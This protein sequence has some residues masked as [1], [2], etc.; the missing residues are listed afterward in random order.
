[1]GK[2]VNGSQGSAASGDGGELLQEGFLAERVESQVPPDIGTNGTNQLFEE[3]SLLVLLGVSLIL[4]QAILQL[5]CECVVV[6]S[7]HL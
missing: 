6:G 4:V 2:A 5:Q 7:Y 1:M 3:G